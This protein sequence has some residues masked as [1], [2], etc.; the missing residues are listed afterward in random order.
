[1]LVVV[2][3]LAVTPAPAQVSR[4][5]PDSRPASPPQSRLDPLT[6]VQAILARSQ[7]PF[8]NK[9]AAAVVRIDRETPP[10]TCRAALDFPRRM[11][12]EQHG[13]DQSTTTLLW[14]DDKVFV[15]RGTGAAALVEGEDALRAGQWRAL[16]RA[17]TLEPLATC[18]R[19]TRQG[20]TVLALFLANGETWRLEHDPE[21]SAPVTLSGPDCEVRFVTFAESAV[22]RMPK[23]IVS[24]E[25]GERTIKVED[26]AVTFDEHVFDDLGTRVDATKRTVAGERKV[27][28]E[29]RPR[30]PQLQSVAADLL[31]LVDDPGAWEARLAL[32]WREMTVLREQGQDSAG[33]PLFF[34]VDGKAR[35]GIPFRPDTE[36]NIPFVQKPGQLV[37]RRAS[38]VVA[39]LHLDKTSLPGALVHGGAV[40]EAFLAERQLQAKGPIRAIPYVKGFS[41]ESGSPQDY[42]KIDV[43][44]EIP[45]Q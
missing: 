42:A 7:G 1:M 23:T 39:A 25:F 43:R 9:L 5:N 41:S 20:P 26:A 38:H 2:A 27:G 32:V 45:I 29:A 44:L 31:L 37:E 14:R 11:R 16:L 35:I 15:A 10:E 34:T 30:K 24:K 22:T 8:Q 17:V 21:R 36:R 19:A 4:S 6:Q 18:K 40:L 33:L 12:L 13:A 28:G 3:L